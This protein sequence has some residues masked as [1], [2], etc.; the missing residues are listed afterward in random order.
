MGKYQV[1][2]PAGLYLQKREWVLGSH[3]RLRV[4]LWSHSRW[5]LKTLSEGLLAPKVCLEKLINQPTQ[6]NQKGE[7]TNKIKLRLSLM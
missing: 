5:S 2:W 4:G 6:S 3:Q 1:T 7:W